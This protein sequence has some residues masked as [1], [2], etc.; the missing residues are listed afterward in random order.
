MPLAGKGA[1]A[2]VQCHL[3]KIQRTVSVVQVMSR[4]RF[5]R[6]FR[7]SGSPKSGRT[8]GTGLK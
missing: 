2:L 1:V 7:V 5:W 8:N 4:L 6:G 3:L